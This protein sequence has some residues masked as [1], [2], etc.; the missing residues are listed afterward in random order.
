[1]SFASWVPIGQ[2]CEFGKA[3][4]K[5]CMFLAFDVLRGI[6][7]KAGTISHCHAMAEM[8]LCCSHSLG[9]E[10]SFYCGSRRQNLESRFDV[11]KTFKNNN[12]CQWSWLGTSHDWEI[13][14]VWS[15][16]CTYVCCISCL[17]DLWRAETFCSMVTNS[18]QMGRHDMCSFQNTRWLYAFVGDGCEKNCSRLSLSRNVKSLDG[19]NMSL[20]VM[21]SCCC[22]RKALWIKNRQT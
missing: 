10:C 6:K 19:R 12:S 17:V 13:V 14:C 2:V 4:Q 7:H 18:A 21:M 15:N 1:M 16:T 8:D 11:V 9:L 3:P 20:P 5:Y 22:C